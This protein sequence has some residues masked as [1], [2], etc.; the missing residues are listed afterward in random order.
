M[1]ALRVLM[2]RSFS[3]SKPYFSPNHP[4]SNFTTLHQYQTRRNL[5]LHPP[6]SDFVKLH[7]LSA[8]DSGIVEVSLDRPGA[9]NA[10]GK[11]MLRGLT[12]AFEFINKESYANVAMITS[13]VPGVFCAGADLKER[14]NMNQ[15]EVK[16]FVN[17]LRSAFLYLE[18]ISIPTI[19]VIEGVALGGGLEMALACDIRICGDNALMGLPE[20]GLAIIP[21]AG[22]TQ[23]LPRLVGNAIAK[24]IIYTGRKIN[25]NEALSIGL[26]NYCVPAGDAYSKAL[27][28]AREINEKGPVAIRMAKRAIS[29]GVETDMR[30]GLAL[31]EDCYDEVLNTKDRLE[32]LSAFVEK[33]KPKYK[34]E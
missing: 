24:E 2:K 10:I 27:A 13:S 23:R 4:F 34:G 29:E 8:P 26:V 15:L 31:E 30:S 33:R 32:G 20:T 21:G 14:R 16:D 9:K 7:K 19:A 5:I 22:G 28:L 3:T 12:H 6:A 1:G 11:E 17:S 25:G 18:E